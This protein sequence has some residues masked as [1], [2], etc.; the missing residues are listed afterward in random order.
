MYTGPR[1]P[2]DYT[3]ADQ[4]WYDFTCTCGSSWVARCSE[5]E[6][7][8]RARILQVSHPV[9]NTGHHD[10]TVRL[11][12]DQPFRAREPADRPLHWWERVWGFLGV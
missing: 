7:V 11:R 4:S 6:S 3:V 1:G 9:K 12:A 5:A 8:L 2:Y 10:V